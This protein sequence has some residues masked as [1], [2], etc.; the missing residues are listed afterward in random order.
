MFTKRQVA[1]I[2]ALATVIAAPAYAAHPAKQTPR[3]TSASAA[4]P[5]TAAQA[6]DW[7]L[8]GRLPLPG[9]SFAN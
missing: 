8:D 1:L 4:T 5:I 6:H 2:A 7:Q 9:P 3:V